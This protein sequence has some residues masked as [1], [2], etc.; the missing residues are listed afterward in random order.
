MPIKNKHYGGI[1]PLSSRS[2]SVQM[3][4]DNFRNFYFPSQPGIVA[5]QKIL[6]AVWEKMR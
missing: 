1:A 6:I 5:L 2:D 3:P 4:A